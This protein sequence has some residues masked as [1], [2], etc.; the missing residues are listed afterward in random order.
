MMSTDTRLRGVG[1][2][3]APKLL[4]RRQD[5]KGMGRAFC[6]IRT[7]HLRGS[8]RF[9]EDHSESDRKIHQPVRTGEHTVYSTT[10]EDTYSST[11]L[12]SLGSNL[13]GPR[14]YSRED[15]SRMLVVSQLLYAV[16][17]RVYST[18]VRF[19]T[20][21]AAWHDTRVGCGRPYERGV[22]R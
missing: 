14:F 5:R 9:T 19:A 4:G 21:Q 17:H 11:A 22:I 3:Y 1:H 12:P 13:A 6:T 16:P 20:S 18:W 7:T 10:H 15:A 8:H 2:H